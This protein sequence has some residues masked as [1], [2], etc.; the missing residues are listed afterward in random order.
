MASNDMMALDSVNFALLSFLL[1]AGE[2]PSIGA[3][4]GT[5][6]RSGRVIE[7]VPIT[8]R[9]ADPRLEI[10]PGAPPIL[11]FRYF[12]GADRHRFGKLDLMVDD[13]GH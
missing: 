8:D 3:L 12:E 4:I 10:A 9:L 7:S 5:I 11:A 2:H 13:A 6:A 1:W